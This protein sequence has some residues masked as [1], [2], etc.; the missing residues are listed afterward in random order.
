MWSYGG[1]PSAGG[2][3]G[4]LGTPVVCAGAPGSSYTTGRI[5][6]GENVAGS[7]W[8]KHLYN[9][10]VML[11]A[12]ASAM[13]CYLML[14]DMLAYYPGIVMTTTTPQVINT[15]NTAQQTRYTSGAGVMTYLTYSTLVTTPATSTFTMTYTNSASVG[16]RVSPS[17]NISNTAGT[18]VIGTLPLTG[19]LAVAGTYGPF[20]NL[21]AGDAGVKIPYSVTLGTTQGSGVGVIVQCYPLAC[22]PVMAGPGNTVLATAR[23]FLF[24]MPTMPRIYDGACLNFLM[25]ASGAV[26]TT[27][28]YSGILDFVW[29]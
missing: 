7:G 2:Y 23:D 29:G 28:T 13:P 18:G 6:C 22:I 24:N 14:V 12:T 25:Y 5:A 26:A 27:A 8:N 19:T 16:S 9:L 17:Q 15:G 1:C 21:Y 20:I 4:S 10:E 3:A 11:N